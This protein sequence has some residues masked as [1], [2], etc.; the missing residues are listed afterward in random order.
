M[1][2]TKIFRKYPYS[3]RESRNKFIA[4]EFGQWLGASVLNIGGGGRHHLKK[5]LAAD[6]QY[7]ELDIDGDPDLKINLETDLPL[8]VADRQ[9]QTVVCTDVLEHLDNL[10]RVFGEIVRIS[11]KYIILSLPNAFADCPS[12]FL[13]KP[14]QNDSIER[15]KHFGKYMKYYGLPYEP[16]PDRHKWFFSFT[17]AEEFIDYQIHKYNLKLVTAM[18]I[19]RESNLPGRVATRLLCLLGGRNLGKD[20]SLKTIWCVFERQ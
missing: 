2:I 11:G 5:Y 1:E 13:G 16:P 9:Y 8:P 17:E 20:L 4:A 15:K 10:H 18:A 12:Y 7:F 3:D 14:Y 19:E 6:K